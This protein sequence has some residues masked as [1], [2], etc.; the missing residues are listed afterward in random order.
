MKSGNALAAIRANRVTGRISHVWTDESYDF[1]A[2]GLFA[3]DA[4]ILE[5]AGKSKP[6]QWWASWDEA[7]EGEL[8]IVGD[9]LRISH[10]A[11]QIVP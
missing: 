4:R 10:L 2:G 1:N 6:F 7:V 11:F 9:A 3:D 5:R 8:E